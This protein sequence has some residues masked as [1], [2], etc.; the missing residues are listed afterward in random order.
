MEIIEF[1]YIIITESKNGTSIMK[2]IVNKDFV[3]K[4]FEKSLSKLKDG[5]RILVTTNPIISEPKITPNEA[6]NDLIK[7]LKTIPKVSL[8]QN[9]NL[10]E[11][12]YELR[13]KYN[14]PT[15]ESERLTNKNK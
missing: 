8:A 7:L 3:I 13:K 11:F 1:E 2:P 12:L 10:S 14:V 4:Y 6:K 9:Q 5:D 15:H